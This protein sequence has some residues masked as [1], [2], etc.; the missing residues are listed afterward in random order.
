MGCVALGIG[1]NGT[2][3]GMLNLEWHISKF[4][5]CN[6]ISLSYGSCNGI[7]PINP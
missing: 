1:E 3:R 4:E 7:D 2:S 5:F 6:G